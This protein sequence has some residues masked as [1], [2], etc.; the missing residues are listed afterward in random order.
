MLTVVSATTGCERWEIN[1]ETSRP[2]HSFFFFFNLVADS[3]QTE[4]PSKEIEPDKLREQNV[5]NSL[6]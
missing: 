3:L 6:S 5:N 2:S 1:I 4:I